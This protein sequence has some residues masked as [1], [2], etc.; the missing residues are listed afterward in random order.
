[1]KTVYRDLAERRLFTGVRLRAFVVIMT[2]FQP[3]EKMLPQAQ[4]PWSKPKLDFLKA[5]FDCRLTSVLPLN[6]IDLIDAFAVPIFGEFSAQPGAH[7][8]AHLGAGDR[9]AAERE[10][11][12]AVVFA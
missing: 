6:R 9:L 1:M 12:S 5:S 2:R 7:D 11:V 8:V 3:P 10:D 4:P